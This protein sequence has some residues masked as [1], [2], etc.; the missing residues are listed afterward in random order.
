MHNAIG[1]HDF[2]DGFM[3]SGDEVNR[4]ALTA[5][6]FGEQ[7]DNEEIIPQT[8][9]IKCLEIKIKLPQ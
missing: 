4:R 5:C 8:T 2:L 1:A 7:L 6:D 9:G 3:H